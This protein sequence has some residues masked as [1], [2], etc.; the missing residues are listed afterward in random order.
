M[1]NLN[2]HIKQQQEVNRGRWDNL[3]R[4]RID[5]PSRKETHSLSDKTTEDTI[6]KTLEWAI[7]LVAEAI[8]AQMSYAENGVKPKWVVRGNSLKQD[9]CRRLAR[10]ALTQLEDS[11]N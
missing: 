3:Q 10:K 5:R 11:N 9:E 4:N 1:T 8:Y 7:E 2:D 6:K